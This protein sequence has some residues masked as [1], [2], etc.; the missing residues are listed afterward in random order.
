MYTGGANTDG[1]LG[2]GS[3]SESFM[4]ERKL[5][6]FGPFHKAVKVSCGDSFTL[7]LDYTHKLYSFGKGSHGR[8]GH[9]NDNDLTQPA[10]VQA[11]AFKN[12]LSLSAGCRHAACYTGKICQ[13]IILILFLLDE[14]VL[15]TWGFN[16][17]E[18]LG[19]GDSDKDYEKPTKVTKLMGMKVK[20]VS[21]GYF[22]TSCLVA[23]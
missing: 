4:H 8:L 17:Y 1:Q 2:C 10:L 19:I 15:Y 16:F 13:L 7:V 12:V 18:Q 9:D 6:G 21:C 23:E 11:L 5:E 3:C 22:H 20:D 14:G